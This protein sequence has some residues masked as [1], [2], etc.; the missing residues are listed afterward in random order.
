MFLFYIDGISCHELSVSLKV[1]ENAVPAKPSLS[2]F[3]N[4]NNYD[5][6]VNSQSVF[7]ALIILPNRITYCFVESWTWFYDFQRFIGIVIPIATLAMNKEMNL[8]C[9][10]LIEVSTKKNASMCVAHWCKSFQKNVEVPE[11]T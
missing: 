7:S 6:D 1:H 3:V 5:T 11:H 8:I 10:R 9:F 4:P 2:W